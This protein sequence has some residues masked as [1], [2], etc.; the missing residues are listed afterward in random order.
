[1]QRPVES[2][3]LDAH[4]LAAL[5]TF[6]RAIVPL[7]SLRGYA[8]P[9]PE[10]IR[11]Q[12]AFCADPFEDPVRGA[13]SARNLRTNPCASAGAPGGTR[14]PAQ[15]HQCQA[16]RNERRAPQGERAELEREVRGGRGRWIEGI[17]TGGDQQIAQSA[18]DGGAPDKKQA[19][20]C[21]D[22]LAAA[23]QLAAH[24][25]RLLGLLAW[26]EHSP[27]RIVAAQFASGQALRIPGRTF[28]QRNPWGGVPGC[29]Y[30][31]DA[32]G[33]GKVV[34]VTDRRQSNRQACIAMRPAGLDEKN[35]SGVFKVT[36][37]GNPRDG[38]SGRQRRPESLDMVLA[39]L[40]NIRLPGGN[41]IARIPRNRPTRKTRAGRER[42]RQASRRFARPQPAG[43][44]QVQGGCR[45]QHP[46]HHRSR[47]AAPRAG[48]EPVL[49][50]RPPPAANGSARGRQEVQRVHHS[51][52]RKGRG[53]HGRGRAGRHPFGKNRGAGQRA[54][55]L[56]SPG[57]RR[58][59]TPGPR[60]PRSADRAALRAGPAAQSC[61]LHGRAAGFDRQADHGDRLF[62]ATRLSQENSR[63][64]R[65]RRFPPPAGRI[66]EFRLGGV[67]QPHVLRRQGMDELRPGRGTYSRRPSC[68]AGMRDARI[69][70]S[71]AGA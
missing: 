52:V 68:S 56:L 1:M 38:R 55:R 64:P 29:I 20:A 71:A 15:D 53:A 6:E 26:R 21:R 57:I 24:D 2:V 27:K 30:Y 51:D 46:P 63:R 31:G 9:T 42:R 32:S 70:R 14:L 10:L 28:E 36:A 40:D 4:R 41:S 45:L 62:W 8:E 35:L 37:G 11:E 43:P 44:A 47:R 12:F 67:P 19:V 7:K 25:G 5:R 3:Y 18:A 69:R 58:P 17:Q 61:A 60:M 59:R 54:F 49:R 16:W 65:V 33:P 48:D 23:R 22:A 13:V 39:D 34:Y 50:G 66:E